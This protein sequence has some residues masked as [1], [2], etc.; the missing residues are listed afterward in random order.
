MID[1]IEET[2]KEMLSDPSTEVRLAASAALDKLRVKKSVSSY[3][4]MLK[5]GPLEER[6]RVVFAAEEI[7]GPEGQS[8]LLAALSDRDKEVRGAAVRAL[9]S[10]MTGP[11]LKAMVAQL[12]GE[13]GVVLGNLLEALGK[14][15]RRELAPIL[16]RYLE[17]PDAEVR[18]KAIQAFA[19][20]AENT[21][22]EKILAHAVEKDETVRA[23]A[24]HALGEWSSA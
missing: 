13:E 14:S 2:L 23:A 22:W 11:V 6:V 4:E 5:T 20:V 16:E 19:R 9:E 24:A 3:L 15:R 10:F 12:P 17:H 1:R 8:L 18:G 21:G 7:G